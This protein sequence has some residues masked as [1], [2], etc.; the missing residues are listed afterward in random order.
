MFLILLSSLIYLRLYR[1]IVSEPIT[2][3]SQTQNADCG[4]VLTGGAGRVKEGF[5]LLSQKRI[6]KLIISGVH[7]DA[8]LRDIFPLW[9]VSGD[10]SEA[11]VILDRRSSTTYGNAQQTYP[12][13]EALRCQDILLITSGV[14]MDRAYR[15]FVSAYPKNFPIIRQTIVAGRGEADL[16]EISNEI[17]KT[18][19]Y[20]LWAF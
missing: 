4:V 7:P 2:S 11:D 5:A 18:I 13:V 3:W 9:P 15:T 16:W 14:H 6:K 12:L 8:H 1:R 19:F 10:L 20:S 17:L